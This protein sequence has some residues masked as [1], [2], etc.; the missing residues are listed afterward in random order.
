MELKIKRE[1]AVLWAKKIFICTLS[2]MILGI[3]CGLNVAAAQGA[4]P[5][6]VFYDGL[7][8][9]I[10]L[11]VGMTAN[12]LNTTLVIIVFFT[13]RRYIHIGTVIY[14]FV[15]GL[16]IQAGI[17]IYNL[18]HIPNVFIWQVI[19]SLFGCLLAFIGLGGFMSIDIGIDPWTAAAV[20]LSKKINKSF[21]LVKISL[22]VITLILGW[23]MGGTVGII[24]LFCAI[25]GGPLIQKSAELLDKLFS[26]MLKSNC[27]NQ[28]EKVK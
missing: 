6:T 23:M 16:F 25:A 28:V 13:N 27:E 26:K 21:R 14:T 22:D 20:I 7:S 17:H 5:I 9:V 15:L 8:N 2:L 24:T 10:R 1:S 19:V 3:A 4:D 12:I 11:N 18:M